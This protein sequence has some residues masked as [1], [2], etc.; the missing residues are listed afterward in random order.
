MNV[1]NALHVVLAQQKIGK[2]PFWKVNQKGK[3]RIK[4]MHHGA[5]L[6]G[7][8]SYIDNASLNGPLFKKGLPFTSPKI[9]SRNCVKTRPKGILIK[10]PIQKVR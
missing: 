1:Q 3:N 8:K 6:T 2:D 9:L 10:R 5:G 7:G 4:K